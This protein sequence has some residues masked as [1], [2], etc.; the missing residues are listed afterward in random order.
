MLL[1]SL[2]KNYII[3]QN[4]RIKYITAVTF[5]LTKPNLRIKK[6]SHKQLNSDV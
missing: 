6:E 2:D 4:R 5:E 3:T 1:N